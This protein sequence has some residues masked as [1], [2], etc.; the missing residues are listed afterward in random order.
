MRTQKTLP[1][2]YPLC[3]VL[4]RF[5]NPA[6]FFI[7]TYNVE[8]VARKIRVTNCKCGGVVCS[9]YFGINDDSRPCHVIPT[10]SLHFSMA[11]CHSLFIVDL[12]C[13][14]EDP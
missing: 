10:V 11:A 7:K 1:V 3:S 2:T 8:I 4:G 13:G 14:M 9:R 12:S 5:V 6:R